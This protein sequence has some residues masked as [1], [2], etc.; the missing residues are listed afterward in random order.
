MLPHI[1]LLLA[2]SG[3]GTFNRS[4]SRNLGVRLADDAE[5][6]IVCDADTIP[7]PGGLVAALAAAPAG[8]LHYPQAVV[9]Y[10][11]ES[12][13]QLLL[14]GGQVESSWV[15][16]SIPAA[17]GGCFVIRADQYRLA[18]QFD[19]GFEGWGFEDNAWW[20]AARRHLGQPTH[21]AGVAWHLWH[22]HDRYAGSL[23]QTR[24]WIRA[25]KALGT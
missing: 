10:L 24:N 22:P 17:H 21:H 5:L 8:G 7:D 12:G 6:V 16:F 14:A 23:E 18:G 9:N 19:E 11:T 20:A 2:D 1:P 13:T 4:A 3:H 15:D 25:R